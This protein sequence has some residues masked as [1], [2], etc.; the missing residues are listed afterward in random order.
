MNFLTSSVTNLASQA[1]ASRPLSSLSG[2]TPRYWDIRSRKGKP[3]PQSAGGFSSL[4]YLKLVCAMV[5][6]E[7]YKKAKIKVTLS[8]SKG[9][10]KS[11][12]E[13][14]EFIYNRNNFSDVTSAAKTQ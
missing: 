9:L 2:T 6:A 5:C 10:C 14:T 4:I 12:T 3:T 8:N 13:N 7:W 11:H 1:T